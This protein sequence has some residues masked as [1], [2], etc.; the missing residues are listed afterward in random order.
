MALGTKNI[1]LN[2]MLELS[3]SNINQEGQVVTDPEQRKVLLS[4][5]LD[6]EL[7][8]FKVNALLVA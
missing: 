1:L 6:S 5:L 7:N 4:Q 3:A 2:S 8:N